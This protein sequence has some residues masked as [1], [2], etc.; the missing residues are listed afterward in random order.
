[1]EETSEND[2]ILSCTDDFDTTYDYTTYDDE[3]FSIVFSSEDEYDEGEC[4]FS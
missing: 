2:S 1:M 4:D 3:D